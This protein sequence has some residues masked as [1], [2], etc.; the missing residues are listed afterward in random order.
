[1]HTFSFVLFKGFSSTVEMNHAR[2]VTTAVTV[3][4]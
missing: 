3:C 1:M 2:T 4:F